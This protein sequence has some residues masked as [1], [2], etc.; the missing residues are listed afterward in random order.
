M[1]CVDIGEVLHQLPVSS[2]HDCIVT[3]SVPYVGVSVGV[4]EDS[5]TLLQ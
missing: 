1:A 5:D 4:F 2:T 3:M